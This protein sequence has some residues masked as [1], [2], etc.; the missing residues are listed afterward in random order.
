MMA[1]HC[2]ELKTDVGS[3]GLLE[4]GTNSLKLYLVGES[5]RGVRSIETM[6]FAWRVGHSFFSTG[7]PDGMVDGVAAALRQVEKASGHVRVADMR[8]IATGVFREIPHF[9]EFARQVRRRT[10]VRVE[11]LSGAAEAELMGEGLRAHHTAGQT[12]L[13]DI[14]GASTEWVWRAEDEDVDYG[15]MRLGAIRSTY[16]Y[17]HLRD[18]HAD[19]LAASSDDCDALLFSELPFAGRAHVVITGGTASAVSSL[20]GSYVVS[21][22]EVRGLVVHTLKNGPPE[23]LKATRRP[24]FLPGLIILWRILLRCRANAF[25]YS[26]GAI[27]HGL[28]MRMLRG[29]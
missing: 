29:E 6:K 15:S 25:R 5:I 16:Q 14:G 4:M 11:L 1:V 19:Y 23:R 18:A 27:R 28:V 7:S 10:S 2:E 3:A 9:D 20:V 24:V 17:E 13:F 12:A 22:N 21:L 26:A 8:A